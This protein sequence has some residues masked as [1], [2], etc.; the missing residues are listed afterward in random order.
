MAPVTLRE[1]ALVKRIVPMRQQQRVFHGWV[2]RKLSASMA[3]L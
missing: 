1:A 3:V 2:T